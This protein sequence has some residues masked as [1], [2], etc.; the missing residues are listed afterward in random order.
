MRNSDTELLSQRQVTQLEK[1]RKSLG[2]TRTVVL[3]RFARALKAAG[4]IH[5]QAAAKMRLDRVF[6]PRMR[7]PTSEATKAALACALDWTLSE[8]ESAIQVKGRHPEERARGSLLSSSALK[9]VAR[10][11]IVTARKLEAGA[12][13]LESLAA[14]PRDRRRK[15]RRS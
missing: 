1:R 11:L 12:R 8:L 9:S 4:W 6:N 15:K 3:E 13:K 2:L 14:K 7:R 5:T 10:D